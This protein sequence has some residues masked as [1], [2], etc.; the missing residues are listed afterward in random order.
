MRR[1]AVGDHL[2]SRHLVI[3]CNQ[4]C[5]RPRLL[6]DPSLDML[7]IVE[8]WIE[9][10]KRKVEALLDLFEHHL[11]LL[12]LANHEPDD[13]DTH[14]DI[15]GHQHDPESVD[16]ERS[17]PDNDKKTN[18]AGCHSASSGPILAQVLG[19]IEERLLSVMSVDQADC[20][21]DLESCSGSLDGPAF[22][23]SKET[24][25]LGEHH[26]NDH[27]TELGQHD[28]DLVRSMFPSVS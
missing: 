24:V 19:G 5:C 18:H 27:G 23:I 25:V 4:Q 1:L 28:N 7:E 6:P 11:E 22:V 20:K 15:G 8:L 16:R 21:D 3:V 9:D 12:R 26:N 2:L 17:C 13:N 14:Q 10:L